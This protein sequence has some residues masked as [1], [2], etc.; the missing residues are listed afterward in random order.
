MSGQ[1]S[2]RT[3]GLMKSDRHVTKLAFWA[4]QSWWLHLCEVSPVAPNSELLHTG[5][6]KQVEPRFALGCV[7]LR[8]HGPDYGLKCKLRSWQA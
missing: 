6:S 7:G 8:I 3:K 1:A 2:S 5:A 4:L